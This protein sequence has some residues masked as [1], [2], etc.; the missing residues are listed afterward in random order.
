MGRGRQTRG[1]G[2]SGRERR[3]AL[4]SEG[5]GEDWVDGVES[6]AHVSTSSEERQASVTAARA[7]GRAGRPSRGRAPG[8]TR[9]R[10]WSRAYLPRGAPLLSAPLLPLALAPRQP[11][12]R[13]PPSPVVGV[14]PASA[15]LPLPAAPDAS[16]ALGPGAPG[17]KAARA[18]GAGPCPAPPAET[19]ERRQGGPRPP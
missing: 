19:S 14:C 8:L 10:P 9:A 7:G 11:R 15:R 5:L 16:A 17:G 13:V 6:A 12:R 18:S 1:R 2:G 4:V 3:P